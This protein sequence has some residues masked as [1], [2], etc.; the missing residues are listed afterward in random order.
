MAMGPPV[1]EIVIYQIP[2]HPRSQAVCQAFAQGIR[3]VGDKVRVLSS[4]G[5][6]KPEGDIAIFYGLA[7][8][9]WRVM[10]D[11]AAPPRRTAI[12]VDLGYWGRKD[13]GRFNGYHKISVNDRHPTS[14]F[15]NRVH[16]GK[17]AA[18]FGI[19][20]RPWRRPSHDAPIVIAGMGPKGARAE[21]YSPGQWER[22]AIDEIRAVTRRPIIYRP[23]PNWVEARPL[24]GS[25]F[26][27]P[28]A[29]PL[30]RQL[31]NCHAL[32]SHHSN[33]G[34]EA[35]VAGVPIF[36]IEGVALPF[37]TALADI[38]KPQ[39]AEGREQWARD[40]A[41]CQWSVPEMAQGLPWRHLKDEGLVP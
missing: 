5:Y 40:V 27:P 37:S 33:A 20:P 4:V 22:T 9:L 2:A 24:P 36:T 12:Y 26:D 17:R 18:A 31:E 21:N 15:Q 16:D 41:Y 35:L 29:T 32:V 3:K 25:I 7:N 23:K 1:A 30:D 19:V 38:E 14:Y 8:R 6:R 39:L 10:K 34:V 11:Y 13:G 28:D